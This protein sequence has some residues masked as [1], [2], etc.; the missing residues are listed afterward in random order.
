ME[1]RVPT[2]SI[3]HNWRQ[4]QIEPAAVRA[5]ARNATAFPSIKTRSA[6][7]MRTAPSPSALSMKIAHRA[8]RPA[9]SSGG[10]IKAGCLAS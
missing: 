3:R 2:D 6:D 10:V 5:N 9:L 4:R 1:P 7:N 8:V